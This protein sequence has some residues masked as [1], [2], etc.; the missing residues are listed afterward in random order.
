MESVAVSTS[1]EPNESDNGAG[2]H[3]EEHDAEIN[4]SD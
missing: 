3:T 1:R 4:T 2:N